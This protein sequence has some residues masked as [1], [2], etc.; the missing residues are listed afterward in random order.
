MATIDQYNAFGKDKPEEEQAL[1]HMNCAEV[2]LRTANDDFNL[3][4]LEKD[5]KMMAGFG[6]G[7]YSGKTCGAFIGALA[8]LG[9]LFAKDRP[10]KREEVQEGA[11]RLYKAFFD[12]FG[13]I[14]C[15]ALKPLYRDPVTGCDPVK[16]RAYE[17]FKRVV[18]QMD[19]ERQE[20]A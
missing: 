2:M 6:A 5:F 17:V 20:K 19:M 13:A 3:G 15:D 16:T 8:A 1:Y 11:Q 9:V 18:V 10:S 14:D 12:E 4:L 7:F